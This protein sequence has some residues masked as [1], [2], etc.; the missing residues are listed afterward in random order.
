MKGVYNL[1]YEDPSGLNAANYAAAQPAKGVAYL[2]PQN[3]F[4]V[5]AQNENYHIFKL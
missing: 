1:K 3:S 2:T 5:P 4:A